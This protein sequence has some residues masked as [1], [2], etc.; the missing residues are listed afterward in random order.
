MPEQAFAAHSE[1][2][3]QKYQTA[4]KKTAI[5]AAMREIFQR[6]QTIP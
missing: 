1:A 5:K 4:P 2:G 6:I 3:G